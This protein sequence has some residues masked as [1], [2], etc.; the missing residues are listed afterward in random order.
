NPI[1]WLTYS[2]LDFLDGRLHNDMTLF[3]YGSGN[4]TLFFAK[5]VKYV[6]SIEHDRAWYDKVKT[7]APENV[8]ISHIPM[9][10][11]SDYERAITLE[12]QLYDIILIDGRR[13]VACLK[14]AVDQ[15]S[16]RG[17]IILDDSEREEYSEAF[18]FLQ[19]RGFKHL[20]FSGIAIGAIHNKSTTVFYRANNTLAI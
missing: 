18:T 9:E 12:P 2:F 1:P 6:R 17:V 5:H 10:N 4:S 20:P 14:N 13:R 16:E 15:L 8:M 11:I 3:E 7:S 19:E